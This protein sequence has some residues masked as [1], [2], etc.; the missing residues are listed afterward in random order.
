MTGFHVELDRRFG[1]LA[2]EV[3]AE[4]AA[5]ESYAADLLGQPSGLGWSDL[6]A[7]PRV[8]VLGEPGSGKTHE[9]QKQSESLRGVDKPAFFVPLERLVTEPL[10]SA[11]GPEDS[12]ALQRWLRSTARAAFFLDSVDE[13]KRRSPRDFLTALDRFAVGLAHGLERATVII[14]SRITEWR[15][16]TDSYEVES[17]LPV[18]RR[19]QGEKRENDRPPGPLVVRLEPLDRDRARRIAVAVVGDMAADKFV[20]GLDEHHAWAFARRPLDVIDLLDYWKQHG[21]FGNLR[22]LI[23]FDVDQ[24]LR[25]TYERSRE[26]P[27][28]PD[29][30]REGAMTLG[31]ATSLCR[32]LDFRVPDDALGEP[33]DAMDPADCLPP[34]WRPELQRSLLDRALFDG[35]S[36]GRIR[37]HHRRV[38][39]Y[40]AA[41]WLEERMVE[42]CPLE[43]LEDFLFDVRAVPPVL[44]PALAPVTAWLACGD[45]PWNEIV[46][47]RILDTNPALFLRFG[48][49][50]SL[51]VEYRKELI[52]R[53][54]Q[55]YAGRQLAWIDAEPEALARIADPSLSGL[56]RD[57][58]AD[59]DA[60][61]ELRELLLLLIRYGRLAECLDVA[62]NVVVDPGETERLKLYAAAAV[63][64]AGDLEAKHRLASV[65]AEFPAISPALCAVV[66]EA[67]YPAAITPQALLDLLAKVEHVS[68]RVAGDLPWRLEQLFD[69]S[70]P[71]EHQLTI[72]QGLLGL[73]RRPPHIH[74]G[75]K[76]S[77][78]SQRF[79][80]AAD[81][82]LTVIGQMLKGKQL[83]IGISIA[84]AEALASL[85]PSRRLFDESLANRKALTEGLPHQEGVRR[86]YTW[87]RVGEFRAA[88]PNRAPHAWELFEFDEPFR[89]SEA[90][91]EW[92]CE[93]I[94]KR[95]ASDD[96]QLA[97]SLAAEIWESIGRPRRW[98]RRT[99]LSAGDH[100]LL[101]RE[102]RAKT[103]ISFTFPCRRFWIRHIRNTIASG[104]WWRRRRHEI[105]SFIRALRERWFLL[106]N[107]RKLRSGEQARWLAGLI[108]TSG[109]RWTVD[110][111]EG[112]VQRYGRRIANAAREGC[113]R[114][115]RRFVPALPH[116]KP[117]S[118]QTDIRVCVGLTGIAA[119]VAE[120]ELPSSSM[121]YDEATLATRYAVNELNAFPPWFFEL[122][123]SHP[124]AV[125]GVLSEC[126][127]GEWA[128]PAA[129][130]SFH[131]V[132]AHLRWHGHQLLPLVE[133][134][135]VASLKRVD[136]AQPSV[137]EDALALLL[138]SRSSHLRLLGNLGA[139]RAPSYDSLDYSHTLWASVWLQTD[140]PR[141]I[142]YLETRLRAIDKPADVVIGLCVALQGGHGANPLV[143]K[144]PAYLAPV[145]MR[146]F[147]PLVY[148]YLKPTEDI[149]RQPG[150]SYSPT[151]RDDAQVMRDRLLAQLAE[152]DEPDAEAVLLDL[153]DEPALGH[154]RDWI[155]HLIEQRRT[156]RA[157]LQP[158]EPRDIQEF[159]R[160][161]E[162]TPRTDGDLFAITKRR[163]S[164]IKK[165]IEQADIS[166]RQ[167]LQGPPDERRLR[168]WLARQLRD[169]SLGRYTVPQE[170]EID[171]SQRPDLRVEAPAVGGVPI[172][173]KWADSWTGPALFERL[174]NQLVGQ[175]LRA[176]DVHYGIYLLGFKGTRE[177]WEHPTEGRRIPFGQLI[178]SLQARANELIRGRPDIHGVLVIG[179]DFS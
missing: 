32:R 162:T 110:A 63:R 53:L 113:K 55:R 64:D 18:G 94:G 139:E 48:D 100:P 68:R 154:R 24:K 172:E 99:R 164:D 8:V 120:G 31:A 5:V 112:V 54:A 50:A 49:P 168:S 36:L 174:E 35:A 59:R 79:Y 157:D 135:L 1:K 23:E 83:D 27:L 166:A 41:Q 61:P 76:E 109:D 127:I 58:V 73:A 176:H 28:S 131:G 141:A 175:Y 77:P 34:G 4:Q 104:W 147:I 25:E 151:S 152:S 177:Q 121:S 119:A 9:L 84:V 80:W 70:L 20:Q 106:R 85:W 39:E 155:L 107:L 51:S 40:L 146:R 37:F 89:L 126:V 78:I 38:A 82:A 179:I 90:D 71:E 111:W 149:V 57:L 103:R 171:R 124:N 143:V 125:G 7:A 15:P 86:A 128:L 137:L 6:L 29:Q 142:A 132:M 14:S 3:D 56:V 163:L 65:A 118:N 117:V 67:L 97:L 165:S 114:A 52:R 12:Q 26:D 66:C 2:P 145:S 153:R 33:A 69:S 123:T 178:V 138:N 75:K 21:S 74:D 98:R 10:A 91:L 159:A 169:R 46:L 115:W 60:S 161:F 134:A 47:A 148:N 156:R 105:K 160:D 13:S 93:D 122:A 116:E 144:N 129:K 43:T 44:R 19:G 92:L 87:R 17:R 22:E 170:A 102:A 96:R 108:A 45:R 11:L 101:K 42:G 150:F 62:I 95:G 16:K 140:A 30:A 167:D 133:S 136:P 173:V 81:V 88:E 130:D 72:L 158:W